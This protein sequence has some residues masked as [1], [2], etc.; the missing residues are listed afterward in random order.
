M[1]S[2]AS[3]KLRMKYDDGF[4]A[5]INGERVASG[6]APDDLVW[7]SGASD[8]HHDSVAVDFV[9][10]DI[11]PFRMILNEGEN[12][13][14]IH[15]LNSGTNSSDMLVMPVIESTKLEF[16]EEAFRYFSSPSG[17][18]SNGGGSVDYRPASRVVDGLVM[19]YDMSEGS[20]TVVNDVSGVGTPANLTI[21]DP[22]DVTW[23]N[24]GISIDD[25]TLI[26]S[27]GG[28]SKLNQAVSASGEISIEAWVQSSSRG[29]SGPARIVT[30]SN[31]PNN[32]NFTLGQEGRRYDVRLRTTNTD[33]NGTNPSL[34][35]GRLLS[36]SSMQHVVYTYSDQTGVGSL[37]VDGNLVETE[38]IGGSPTNWSSSFRF[39]LGN[40]VTEDRDWQGDL[41]LVAV[42]SKALSE[43][44][45]D[46]NYAQGADP[47]IDSTAPE[48]TGFEVERGVEDLIVVEFSEDVSSRLNENDVTLVNL[49]HGTTVEV[50]DIEVDLNENGETAEIRFP[51]LGDMLPA[52]RYELR[53]RSS[54]IYDGGGNRLVGNGDDGDYVVGFLHGELG[55]VTLDD[56]INLGDLAIFAT[57]FGNT[58]ATWEQGDFN[59]DGEVNLEDLANLATQFGYQRD[60]GTGGGASEENGEAEGALLSL[61]QLSAEEDWK[62]GDWNHIGD[63]LIGDEDI[64]VVV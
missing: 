20:G 23:T 43:D 41:N 33:P 3:L 49:T 21:H 5:Y 15:G 58:G 30:Y 31:D 54:S 47:M 19:L 24:G 16:A 26:A 11:S 57:H 7:N 46:K 6:N 62:S 4:V 1:G 36:S 25:N 8:N 55:D 56:K 53:L 32:R 35:S 42:Y 29:H 61:N 2:V 14:A 34:R 40:E 50:D 18:G 37:Y 13:L 45:V 59:G 52:G 12:L 63:I 51:G 39:A 44:E 17:G 48:V 60:S 9:D 38:S 22:N 27:S 10:F 28:I 64:I